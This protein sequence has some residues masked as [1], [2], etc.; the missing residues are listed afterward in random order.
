[1][2]TEC[3]RPAAPLAAPLAVQAGAGEMG[4]KGLGWLMECLESIARQ[5]APA[6]SH[7]RA[8]STM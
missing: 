3:D 4:L 2:V 8:A 5:Q 7:S 6:S 1:M